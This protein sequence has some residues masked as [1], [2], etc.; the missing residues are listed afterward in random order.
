MLGG[1]DGRCAREEE[2]PC[3]VLAV[4]SAATVMHRCR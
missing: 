1:K 3:V 4:L 2:G